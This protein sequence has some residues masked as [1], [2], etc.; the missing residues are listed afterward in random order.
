MPANDARQRALRTSAPEPAVRRR[1][2]VGP[3]GDAAE[4]DADSRADA[5][6]LRLTAQPSVEHQLGESRIAR[7]PASDSGAGDASASI[8][9]AGGQLGAPGQRMI[10]GERGSGRALDPSVRGS[11]ESAF[12]AD[13]GSVRIH[14]NPVAHRVSRSIAA[15]AFTTG[16]DVFFASGAYDPQSAR[17][18][19]VLAHELGHVVQNTG[20]QYASI[21]RLW[22]PFGKTDEQKAKH[23]TAKDKKKALLRA[24][25][26]MKADDATARIE[27]KRVNKT[28]A[29]ESAKVGA[30]YAGATAPKT[31]KSKD[32]L[33][34][35]TDFQTYLE[36]ERQARVAARQAA[37]AT[38]D[39]EADLEVAEE[40]AAD[41]VWMGAP[42]RVRAF[43]P[44][45]FDD[46][47]RALNEVR[48]MALADKADEVGEASAVMV[49]NKKA[50]GPH[51]DPDKAL[52]KVAEKRSL[53]RRQVRAAE[54][55]GLNP[56]DVAAAEAKASSDKADAKVAKAQAKRPGGKAEQER[57]RTD[58]ARKDMEEKH[59]PNEKLDAAQ[60]AFAQAGTGTAYLGKA[61][62]YGTAG[63]SGAM[64]DA[65]NDTSADIATI[66]GTSTIG[67]GQVMSFISDVLGFASLVDDIRNGVADPGAN[68]VAVQR[69]V[70]ALSSAA[71]IARTALIAA[72][73]GVHAF[74]G[75]ANV[76]SDVG[77][78]LPIVGLITSVLGAID[79]ALDLIPASVRLG[80]GLEAVDSAVL[81][82]K[83]PLAAAMDRIN[84]RNIQLV[85]KAS[86]DIAKHATMI[87][88]HI[89]EIGSAGGMG[90]PLAAKLSVTIV[91]IAH[92]VGHSIYDMVNES[93]S[94]TAK[95]RFGVKHQEGA[96]RDVLKYDIGSSVDVLIVAA[97]KHKL[98]YARTVLL[99]YGATAT[100]VD[101]MRLHELRDK[102]VDGLGAE[103]DPK[104]VKEKVDAAKQ[105]VSDA[106][107][108]EKKPTGAKEDK[109]TLDTV[110]A[111]PVG[112]GK[113]FA[114][115]PSVI[116]GQINAIK[117]KHSDA[118]LLQ[119]SKN[120]VGYAGRDD[121]G[122]G[123]VAAHML[124][125]PGD[126]EKSFAKVRQDLAA[127]GTDASALP[128][129]SDHLKATKKI[130]DQKAVGATDSTDQAA[131]IDKAFIDTVT[132]AGGNLDELRKI[133]AA[134]DIKD[135]A[136]LMNLEY[137]KFVISD[138]LARADV[139]AKK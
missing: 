94:S 26:A 104:T 42:V 124:R 95:K 63:I 135:P 7:S 103:G 96:S 57:T 137:I 60:D 32:H 54:S 83:A 106:L 113:A 52:K 19:R 128:Y 41:K 84:S 138:A 75:A 86:F 62:K 88:L 136:Q 13:F 65:A 89:A 58:A 76:I 132:K 53:E 12:G 92:N 111:V 98:A 115:L 25:A 91:G 126:V 46:F 33:R 133:H 31:D 125:L 110:L 9:A 99:D 55:K 100:E 29:A 134:M 102:I 24:R 119:K 107:G 117:E 127:N 17:G 22:S 77:T 74:G 4:S 50:L 121:R 18:Q 139:K 36:R 34:L 130:D 45:R 82:R 90:A 109:S 43:R 105:S 10:D 70:G 122:R 39:D 27:A 5:A 21:Q 47:D 97:R 67:L 73:D 118:K 66:V 2:D 56:Q 3:A 85:E 79:S 81:A 87:G 69:G 59:G 20:G 123:M 116:G 78:A 8:G 48:E 16:S 37:E 23:A 93:K 49:D 71:G 35:E 101:T 6:L 11:M 68:L 112:I 28:T 30:S 40:E 120:S 64:G 15:E 80:T 61:Q 114:G 44:L 131:Q 1:L 38:T 72:R 108:I 51:L 14:D 129:S